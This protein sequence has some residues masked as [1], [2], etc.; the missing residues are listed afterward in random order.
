MET[1]IAMNYIG[2]RYALQN[3]TLNNLLPAI[4]Q[5]DAGISRRFQMNTNSALKVA[6][7]VKNITNQYNQY[8]RY[9]VLPGINYQIKLS[10]E[11]R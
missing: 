6:F 7:V 11:I 5:I 8:I 2:N 10:Y 3:N 4:F 1:F 9:F